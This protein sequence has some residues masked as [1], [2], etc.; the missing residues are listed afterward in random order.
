AT[1]T[2]T[3]SGGGTAELSGGGP[4]TVT[5]SWTGTA[6]ST[7]DYTGFGNISIADG[8]P[9]GSITVTSVNDGLLEPDET[10]IATITALTT[11][12][13]TIGVPSFATTTITEDKII[14]MSVNNANTPENGSTAIFTA[15]ISGGGTATSDVTVTVTWTGTA[16]DPADYTGSGNITISTGN[17]SGS[18]T[19]TAV[20]DQLLEGNETVIATISGVSA[21]SIGAPASA[22]TTITD[23]VISL[24]AVG[25]PAAENAGVATFVATNTLTANA[26]ITVNLTWGGTATLT[27]DYTRSAATITISNGNTSGSVTV[28]GVSDLVLDPNETVTAVITSVTKGAIAAVP[29]TQTITIADDET[30]TDFIVAPVNGLTGVSVEPT[31]T[32]TDLA[33]DGLGYDVYLSSSGSS[34]TNFESNIFAD[35]DTDPLPIPAIAANTTSFSW[36]EV[37]NAI[38]L[39][40]STLY[41]LQV[42]AH[43]DAHVNHYS[44]IN[45]FTTVP[46][47]TVTQT[48]PN[49][50]G[51]VYTLS[52]TLYW[53]TGTTTGSMKYKVQIIRDELLA[54]PG[55][56][57]T[58]VEWTTA[59]SH[60][61]TSLNKQVSVLAGKTYWWR[62]IV[63]NSSSEVISYS[64]NWS[65]TVIGGINISVYQTWPTGNQTVYTN[66]PSVYWYTDQYPL[67]VTYKV[68]YNI[69]G[70]NEAVPDGH[71]DVDDG[72]AAFV[73]AGANLNAQLPTLLP[74]TRYYWSVEAIYNGE[75]TFSGIESFTTNGTGTLA[76]PIPSYPTGGV[77]VY[78]TS[79]T[80][81][82]YTGTDISGLY[83]D[84]DIATASGGQDGTAD[85][86]TATTGLLLKQ[87]S[88]LTPGQTYYYKIRSKNVVGVPGVGES[89]AWSTEASFVV[90]GSVANG[91]PVITWPTGNPTLYTTQPSLYWY[92]EGQSLGLTGYKIKY[93]TT[94]Q[95]AGAGWAAFAPGAPD[96]TDGEITIGSVSTLSYDFLIDL[97]Y[98][99][100]YYWAIASTGTGGESVY[101]TASFTIYGPSSAIA[102]TLSFP[103]D[104]SLDL[105]T[106]VSLSWFINGSTT[107][108]I[109]YT[110]VY[111]KSDV[112]AGGS[113]TTETVTGITNNTYSLT[114]LTPGATYYWKVTAIYTQ[115]SATSSTW[116]FSINPGSSAVQPIVGGPNNVTVLT[117]SPTLSWLLLSQSKSALTYQLE[118]ADNME[119]TSPKVYEGLTTPYQSLSGLKA[120]GEYYWRVKSANATGDYSYYSNTG[121]FI[122][123]DGV[124][125]VEENIIP[126]VFAMDQN[127]PN[128]FNPTTTIQYSIP[129][130]GFV[131]LKIFNILGQEVTTL[132][133]REM[134][135]GIYNITWYGVDDAGANVATGTY[136]YR[137]V[138]GSNVVSKKMILLK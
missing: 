46:N 106:S 90:S 79:P 94:D 39:S 57:P 87:I 86:S 72:A 21:G 55:S 117:S 97:T 83:F 11:G 62:V 121:K 123:A 105:Q 26:D 133:N 84:I 89:S 96:A 61:V 53:Y 43:Q 107:G 59:T 136:I 65:F 113:P 122:V 50:A 92:L 128:P 77:T 81:Y 4:I 15:S 47:V 38:P 127:Y 67:G 49:N 35:T 40:N 10:I 118:L 23:E 45:H 101:A 98:G 24:S 135:P 52:P 14:V 130:A 5:L 22:T 116:S 33:G 60:I 119:F 31:I 16:T 99:E 66:A 112:F 36:A 42:I 34:Q 2:A 125:S 93:S 120:G 68:W 73:S 138:S 100:T 63:L 6:T 110:L 80:I 29:P 129:E 64:A 137:L 17:P 44:F 82:W 95:A 74:G 134:N 19:I 88:G 7:L 54:V 124:T 9:S 104:G 32:W 58:E 103:S 51:T 25:S 69:L 12:A 126:T 70:D 41:Y 76:V 115:G 78:T 20:D 102:P 18:V 28:T 85:F 111:S 114:G 48:S 109:S 1:F 13:G 3:I 131:S 71:I 108:F 27:T 91:Y 37:H 30:L 132:L 56:A 75:S 8:A